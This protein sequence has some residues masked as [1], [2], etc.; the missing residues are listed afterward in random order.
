MTGEECEKTHFLNV[1]AMVLYDFHIISNKQLE[2]EIL[3]WV[4]LMAAGLSKN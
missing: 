2:V 1:R 4:R 3:E